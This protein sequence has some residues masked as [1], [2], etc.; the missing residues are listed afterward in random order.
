MSVGC[1]QG[2]PEEQTVM[3]QFVEVA[4]DHIYGGEPWGQT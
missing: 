2:S 3:R 4:A 1:H